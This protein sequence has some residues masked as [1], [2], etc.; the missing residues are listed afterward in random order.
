M[1]RNYTS[2][3]EPN[4]DS[5]DRLC[6]KSP[7]PPIF[8]HIFLKSHFFI[9]SLHA[10][11]IARYQKIHIFTRDQTKCLVFVNYY[12]FQS[13]RDYRVLEDHSTSY[14]ITLLSDVWPSEYNSRMLGVQSESESLCVAFQASH[15]YILKARGIRAAH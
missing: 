12:K 5:C 6:G 3:E 14:N 9:T 13:H 4:Q 10:T 2:Q 8:L 1:P 7:S 11:Y 15:C